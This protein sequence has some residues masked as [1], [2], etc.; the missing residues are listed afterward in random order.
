MVVC[1]VG[2]VVIVYVELI[3]GDCVDGCCWMW[4]LC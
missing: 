3:F 4:L 1:E 2:D